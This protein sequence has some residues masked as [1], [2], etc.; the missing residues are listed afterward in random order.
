MTDTKVGFTLKSEFKK[1]VLPQKLIF[2]LNWD[3]HKSAYT[4]VSTDTNFVIVINVYPG[5]L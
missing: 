3:S 2:V 4:I 5:L 1:I